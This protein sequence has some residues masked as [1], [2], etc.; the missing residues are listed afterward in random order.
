MWGIMQI[1]YQANSNLPEQFIWLFSKTS[2]LDDLFLLCLTYESVN[3][4]IRFLFFEVIII[5]ILSHSHRCLYFH[6]GMD[7]PL[8]ALSFP[9]PPFPLVFQARVILTKTGLG[10]LSFSQIFG[11]D[12]PKS[13]PVIGEVGDMGKLSRWVPEP[14]QKAQ[15][16]IDLLLLNVFWPESKEGDRKTSLT[17]FTLFLQFLFLCYIHYYDSKRKTA[18]KYPLLLLIQSMKFHCNIL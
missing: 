11:R 8:R 9:K 14:R 3:S 7:L 17:H 12:T 15:L 1:L 10:R 4:L 6:L 13:C 2:R 18:S 5:N 16:M